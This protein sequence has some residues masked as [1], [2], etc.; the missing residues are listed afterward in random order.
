MSYAGSLALDSKS[1]A[2]RLLLSTLGL[3]LSSLAVLAVALIFGTEYLFVAVLVALVGQLI[4]FFTLVAWVSV[5]RERQA[6]AQ[7]RSEGKAIWAFDPGPKG[8]PRVRVGL[9]EADERGL[10]LSLEQRVA[11]VSWSDITLIEAVDHGLLRGKAIVIDGP[12][13]GRV[14]LKIL[15][16]D[17]VTRADDTAFQECF[18]VLLLLQRGTP[19]A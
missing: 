6:L 14:E 7:G 12:V 11:R 18:G 1:G 2:A 17:A 4:A 16:S 13:G 10:A 15:G 8:P 3:S 5:R 9:L 19:G